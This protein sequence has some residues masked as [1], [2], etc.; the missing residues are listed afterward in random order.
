MDMHQNPEAQQIALS[1]VHFAGTKKTSHAF[2]S[3]RRLQI[4]RSVLRLPKSNRSENLK[5]SIMAAWI[6]TSPIRTVTVLLSR[7][8]SLSLGV[9]SERVIQIVIS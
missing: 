7:E 1:C 8:F 4:I 3:N 5:T 6:G 2:Y 9:S